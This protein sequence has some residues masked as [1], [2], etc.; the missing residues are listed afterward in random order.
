MCAKR[1]FW[2]LLTRDVLSVVLIRRGLKYFYHVIR[3]YVY[4][5]MYVH[6]CVR[7]C[8]YVS[9]SIRGV[10][11]PVN[12]KALYHFANLP[13]ERSFRVLFFAHKGKYFNS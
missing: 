5:Y 12:E 13:H 9:D 2:K 4:P 6:A 8:V 11:A 10:R 1:L 7:T 3:I